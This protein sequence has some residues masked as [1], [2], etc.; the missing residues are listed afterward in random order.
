MN[1]KMIYLDEV[2]S[3]ND[4][5]LKEFYHTCVVAKKQTKGRG[6]CGRN[7]VSSD[8][9]LFFS[10]VLEKPKENVHLLSFVV[11]LSVVE[12]LSSVGAQLKWPNDVLIDGKKVA[13]IL[14]ECHED[15]VVAGVGINTVCMPEGDFLYP[16]TSLNGLYKNEDL[17]HNILRRLDENCL[18]F[19]ENGF[20]PIRQKCM[21]YIMGFS[22][23][24]MVRLP[25]EEVRGVFNNIAC[26]GAMELQLK[27]SSTRLIRAGDVFLLNE[28]IKN[29]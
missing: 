22:K 24:I 3:T 14:L 12:S 4:E 2:L 16:I 6:R 13:G 23:E 9:N 25:M 18:L 26:D 11:A 21:K 19:K 7:W 5:A 8:G 29:E 15:K 1:W 17:L 20:E 28:G 27:D 10:I